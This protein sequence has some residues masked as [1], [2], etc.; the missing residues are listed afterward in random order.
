MMKIFLIINQCFWS[1]V[2][3]I[4]P[5]NS[6]CQY[7]RSQISL[8]IHLTGIHAL[9]IFFSVNFYEKRD[10]NE[11]ST[12][13]LIFLLSIGPSL[14]TPLARCINVGVRWRL[15]R[16]ICICGATNTHPYI[17]EELSPLL[18]E[19]RW[20]V[21]VDAEVPGIRRGGTIGT[22]SVRGVYLGVGSFWR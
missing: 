5:K 10:Q 4:W 14:V 18:A 15:L 21:A 8:N 13:T 16:R 19:T 1:D 7:Q 3:S 20:R 11:I 9:G 17:S 12:T 2:S 6:S 22:R